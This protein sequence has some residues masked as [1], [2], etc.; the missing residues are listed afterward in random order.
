MSI[1][2]DILISSNPGQTPTSEAS[3]PEQVYLCV[4]ANDVCLRPGKVFYHGG[5]HTHNDRPYLVK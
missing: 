4:W 3:E 5:R 1:R 2:E